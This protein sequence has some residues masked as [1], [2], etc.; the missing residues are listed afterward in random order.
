[1]FQLH[2]H[3]QKSEHIFFFSQENLGLFRFVLKQF[4]SVFCFYMETESFDVSIESKQTEDQPKQFDREH[5]FV[6]FRK[7]RVV[8][9]C[10]ETVLLVSVV[11]I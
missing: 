5:I 11:S 1:V 6:F 3:K 4:A 7:F 10:F 8:S 9:V 2:R